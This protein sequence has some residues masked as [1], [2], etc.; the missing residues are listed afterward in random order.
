MTVQPEHAG[1]WAAQ[2]RDAARDKS[3]ECHAVAQKLARTDPLRPALVA[4]RN[5]FWDIES[6][7]AA[8]LMERKEVADARA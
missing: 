3:A 1:E 6:Q 4:A 2:V 7:L 8:A 5:A